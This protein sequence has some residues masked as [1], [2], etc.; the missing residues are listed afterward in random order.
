MRKPKVMSKRIEFEGS[1]ITVAPFADGWAVYSV[2]LR[3]TK[4]MSKKAAETIRAEMS[5]EWLASV[6]A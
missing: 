6:A 2:G 5:R 3:I 1:F 4:A